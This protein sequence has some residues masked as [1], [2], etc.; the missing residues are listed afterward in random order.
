[1]AKSS[2][3]IIDFSQVN[4]QPEENEIVQDRATKNLF[5]YRENHWMLLEPKS[6][7]PEMSL[8]EL[9]KQ[10]SKQQFFLS[11][12]QLNEKARI[13][14]EWMTNKDNTF[15]MLYGKE[16]SY[17]SLFNRVHNDVITDR[18][19]ETLLA[20]GDIRSIDI[21]ED[22]SGIEIWVSTKRE[23]IETCLYLFPYDDG[24]IKI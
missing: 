6:L 1:M 7:A 8:Y 19:K 21:T 2:Y 5:I 23:Q 12:D 20:I 16:I 17:F 4:Y 14:K 11:E 18:I 22:N 13:I 15:Y 3:K 9:N 10:L 24:V